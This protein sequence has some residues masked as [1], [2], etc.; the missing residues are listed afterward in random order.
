[1]RSAAQYNSQQCA[2]RRGLQS[3]PLRQLL[4]GSFA[5]VTVF[6]AKFKF[7]KLPTVL[8]PN[9]RSQVPV[10]D[11]NAR[12]A[13][14]DEIVPFTGDG[15]GSFVLQRNIESSSMVFVRVV[16]ADAP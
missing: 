9:K 4:Q 14:A 10:Q 12:A 13:D 16:R 2:V 3:L 11:F 5:C 7:S 1:M 8:A 6:S 15:S